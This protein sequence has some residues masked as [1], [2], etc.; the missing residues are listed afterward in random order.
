MGISELNITKFP[1]TFGNG[2]I[3]VANYQKRKIIELWDAPQLIK[4]II[5]NH[6][7]TQ[8][9]VKTKAKNGD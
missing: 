1:K 7:N 5:M 4:L 3:K 9:L 6:N 2:P 8:A